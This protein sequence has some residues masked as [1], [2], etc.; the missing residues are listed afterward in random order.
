MGRVGVGRIW[1]VGLGRARIEVG[2]FGGWRRAC[3]DLTFFWL[4][5]LVRHAQSS[6]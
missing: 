4:R 2:G 5:S 6:W 1:G 3:V